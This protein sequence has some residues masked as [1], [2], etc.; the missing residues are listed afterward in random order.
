MTRSRAVAPSR[1]A[2]TGAGVVAAGVALGS[3]ELASV[4]LSPASPGLVAVV[5]GRLVD[6][7]AGSL[8]DL[9]VDL[10]GTNDKA[11][12][13]AGIVIVGLG[14]GGLLGLI[15]RRRL[16]LAV[17]GFAAF[18][19][20]GMLAARADRQASLA[21]AAVADAVGVAA[22]LAT[23]L[24]LLRT[25]APKRVAP[26]PRAAPG[27]PPA[28]AR[29]PLT[30]RRRFLGALT[31]AGVVAVG[32]GGLA[33]V[34]QAADRAARRRFS[35][36][37]PPARHEVAL[38]ATPAP[39]EV[40]GL[41]P[42]LTPNGSFYRIDTAIFVP[43]VDAAQ[44]TLSITGLVDHPMV[45]T[46]D[47]LLGLDLVD[48]PVTLACVSNDVGGH[49]VDNAVWRGV[50]LADLLRRAGA[51]PEATQVVGHSVDDFTAG[52]PSAHVFDGRVALVAVGMN[53]TALP[54][55]HGFPARLVVAGLYGYVSATKWLREIELTRLEDVDGYWVTRGW[56]KEAP[57][58]LQS[59]IDVPRSGAEVAAGTV[60]LAG[61]AWA[62]TLGISAVEVKVDDGPWRPARLGASANANT[63]V[64]W[65]TTATLGPGLHVA[66]VRAYDGQGRA[67]VE[68]PSYA[69]PDGATGY[70]YRGFTVR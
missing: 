52:F 33:R 66:A 60:A 45:L 63:W 13:V 9:A 15:A 43:E 22:G 44:W 53:G 17:V 30:D 69:V 34:L 10:F 23:L 16:V 51:R 26:A 27:G 5:A 41:T 11:A 59:R 39:A 46:Y 36:P 28:R 3:A 62:P 50:P 42:Y 6:A 4:V 20:V 1:L 70:H 37:L 57:I 31:A 21:A 32:A 47:E 18:G 29:P 12:L 55:A 54:P 19:V 35:G 64:Q 2:A 38:P 56:A 40:E 25:A 65:A 61:V 58:K 68:Q 8:K 24:A 49:L 14:A 7:L 48:E 67:Q